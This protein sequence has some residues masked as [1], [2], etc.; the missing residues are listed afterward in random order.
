MK[1]VL[2]FYY[3]LTSF[4][5]FDFIDITAFA[6]KLG[7]NAE[8]MRQYASGVKYPSNVEI[9]KIADPYLYTQARK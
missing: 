5:H 8:L 2:R 6:E 3:N 4:S 7:I 1:Y 9:K